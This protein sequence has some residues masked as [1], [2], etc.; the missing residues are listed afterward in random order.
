MKGGE[1]MVENNS[2]N[3]PTWGT[4]FKM[5]LTTGI[6]IALIFLLI[7]CSDDKN[8]TKSR[9]N[10]YYDCY[11]YSQ[12]LVKNKLK[13]PKSANFPWYSNDFIKDKGNKIIVS[14]YVDADNS[15]GTNV[16][17]QYVATLTI[18]DG[19]VASGTATILE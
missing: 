8:K 18:K 17:V 19:E 2:N 4:I 11:S 12:E 16:R 10:L 14:A 9:Q 7:N 5:F 6:I 13:S 15:F 1:I 3:Q